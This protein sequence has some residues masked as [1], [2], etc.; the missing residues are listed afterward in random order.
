MMVKYNRKLHKVRKDKHVE[1]PLST[2]INFDPDKV[3]DKV[4]NHKTVKSPNFNFMLPR[5]QDHGP[6]PS[7]MKVSLIINIKEYLFQ[8]IYSDDYRKNFEDE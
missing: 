2:E 8:T 6:L 4:N 7:F 5:P 3:L 1:G